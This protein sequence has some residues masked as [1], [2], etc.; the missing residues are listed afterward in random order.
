MNCL[1]LLGVDNI[2]QPKTDST[3]S[4]LVSSSRDGTIIYVSPVLREIE[5]LYMS[6]LGVSPGYFYKFS[7]MFFINVILLAVMSG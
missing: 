4:K 3:L 7:L 2:S 5:Q 6:L 1:N